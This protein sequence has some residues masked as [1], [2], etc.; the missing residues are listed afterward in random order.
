M[1]IASFLLMISL[2]LLAG[3]GDPIRV[4]IREARAAGMNVGYPPYDKPAVIP[5]EAVVPENTGATPARQDAQPMAVKQTISKAAPAPAKEA[6]A[7]SPPQSQQPVPK[8]TSSQSTVPPAKPDRP[9]PPQFV[10]L[11]RT[12]FIG[13]SITAFWKGTM[14]QYFSGDTK[15]DN[16]YAG[17][18]TSV[19]VESFKRD[20]IDPAPA[21]VLITGGTNDVASAGTPLPISAEQTLKNIE[22]MAETA[23]K[24]CIRVIIGSIPPADKIPW[25]PS[26]VAGQM[27]VS[28][29]DKL[30][31]YAA[32]TG[33]GYADFWTPLHDPS[34]NGYAMQ[35]AYTTD[36]VHPNADGYVIMARVADQAFAKLLAEAASSQLDSANCPAN[37]RTDIR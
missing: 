8:S 1:W 9:P 13:D 11:P 17:E 19:M 35:A 14:P 22:L 24:N 33:I 3:C 36:G 16:G 20:A 21:I 29:N 12:V 23:R 2:P 26:V 15:I 34:G 4:G 18:T 6:V 28:L 32:Q 30:K 7:D 25:V 31:A 27:I 10:N 5:A 37:P